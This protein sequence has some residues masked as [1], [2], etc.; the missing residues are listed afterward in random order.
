MTDNRVGFRHGIQEAGR[1]RR[2]GARHE[3]DHA[4]PRHPVARVFG[5]AQERQHVL[6]VGGLQK[7]EPAELDE[8]NIA[9]GQLDLER[10]AVMGGAEQHRLRLQGHR[11]LRGSASTFSTT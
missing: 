8:R 5:P 9:P 6:D 3:L 11:R 4:E 10:A 1:G 7:L 2:P